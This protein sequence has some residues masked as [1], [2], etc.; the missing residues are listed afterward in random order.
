MTDLLFFLL[1]AMMMMLF[2]NFF[3]RISELG[4]FSYL[5]F[6]ILSYSL[7]LRPKPAWILEF[8]LD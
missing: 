5:M 2:R 6:K 3:F 4:V 7:I 8:I 1:M